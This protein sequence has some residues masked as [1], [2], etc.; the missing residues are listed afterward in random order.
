M[1]FQ[2]NANLLDA[3]VLSSVRGQDAYGYVLTQSM[4]EV[5]GISESTLYPVL[6][7]L[8]Q[9]GF[10]RVYDEPFGGR[11]RRYYSITPDG[12]VQAEA[13]QREWTDFKE[14]VDRLITPA[15]M[16]NNNGQTGKGEPHDKL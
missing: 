16:P 8:Q 2:V 13:Y 11:N 3:C 14:R 5:L 7:R 6:R 12:I 15:G 9:L 4:K 10:L 1:I